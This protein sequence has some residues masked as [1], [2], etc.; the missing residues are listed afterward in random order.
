M[1]VSLV[2]TIAITTFAVAF[3]SGV[4]LQVALGQTRGSASLSTPKQLKPSER[5]LKRPA[6]HA[7]PSAGYRARSVGR[8][9]SGI[10]INRLDAVDVDAV[11][12]LSVS[13]G[14]FGTNL[15]KGSQLVFIKRL[16]A[17]HPERVRSHVM[18]GLLRRVL[19]SAATPPRGAE[20]TAFTAARLKALMAM[21]EYKA[22][23]ALL[24][25]I[26]RKNREA[27]FLAL[28]VE[29]HL[30][31]GKVV[32][33]CGTVATEVTRRKEAFWQKAL[34]YCQILASETSKA[35]LGLTLLQEN[36]TADPTF[37]TLAESMINGEPKLPEEFNNISLLHLAMLQTAK[38]ALPMVTARQYPAALMAITRDPT[39]ANRLEALEIAAEE[40]LLTGVTLRKRYM[41]ALPAAGSAADVDARDKVLGSLGRAWLY[42]EAS[43]SKIPVAK[44]EALRRIME[45]AS[46]AGRLGGV[47]RLFEPVVNTLTP[48][49]D[50]LWVASAAFRMQVLTGQQELAA[51]WFALARRNASISSDASV[52]YQSL[53]PLGAMMQVGHETHR[54]PPPLDDLSADQKI[55]YLSLFHQLGGEVSLELLETL[56]YRS[57]RPTPLP[58]PVL[59]LRMTRL[60][61]QKINPRAQAASEPISVQRTP[62]P[63]VK[64]V[65]KVVGPTVVAPIL[66][67]PSG[68]GSTDELPRLG[69][70]ILMMLVIM[71]DQSLGDLNPIVISEIVHGLKQAGLVAEARNLAMEV[72]VN[73]GL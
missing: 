48:E 17:E 29:L 2:R 44:A 65:E 25:A 42:G 11:G 51:A 3:V 9:L 71:G 10:Q 70:R 60:N 13:Q 6:M 40:G 14:G 38:L 54:K 37:M 72:A 31:T 5:A 24:E 26:P 15:W 36:E 8:S 12:V 68:G 52:I 41:A 66:A 50:L 23:L 19:L 7:Q 35:E 30:V 32:K 27:D 64:P 62:A 43:R 56:I 33:A 59:W 67:P 46:E 57:E 73:A 69:E 20:G 4:A 18:R 16:L 1:F 28:E 47:A 61:D 58:D 34:I 21:G 49:N 53:I 39:A 55:L 22:G 63:G 45:S